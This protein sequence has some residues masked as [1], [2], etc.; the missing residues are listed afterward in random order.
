MKK[1]VF[2]LQLIIALI[3]GLLL[4]A[5][6]NNEQER[7][8]EIVAKKCSIINEG[9][10]IDLLAKF[11]RKQGVYG[12]RR[13]SRIWTTVTIGHAQITIPSLTH[14]K[15]T[16]LHKP[17]EVTRYRDRRHHITI[18]IFT[19][20]HVDRKFL[21]YTATSKIIRKYGNKPLFFYLDE[22]LG[23]YTHGYCNVGNPE[24]SI[25]MFMARA[26]TVLPGSSNVSI[27]RLNRPRALLAVPET[28]NNAKIMF[29]AKDP[30][31]ITYEYIYAPIRFITSLVGSL[32]VQSE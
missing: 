20:H 7:R 16:V 29:P 5:C 10:G 6:G 24:K 23:V 22:A 27:Y 4:T 19:L 2:R 14:S 1:R 25:A 11:H 18:D 9:L 28:M 21:R 8:R 13:N 15:A 12:I 17:F 31:V 30:D 3:A 26:A 32:T